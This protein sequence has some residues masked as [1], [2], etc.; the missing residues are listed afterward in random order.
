MFLLVI[1]CVALSCETE[2][3]AVS[4]HY[5]QG[6]CNAAGEDLY[7]SNGIAWL[8]V[9]DIQPTNEWYSFE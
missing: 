2:L 8:C 3:V 6:Q 5:T 4:A 1:L 7:A 9:K